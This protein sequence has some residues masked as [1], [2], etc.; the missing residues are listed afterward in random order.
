[1]KTFTTYDRIPKHSIYL[2]STYP[3]GSMD[4]FVADAIDQA[5]EPVCF[6]DPEGVKHY[7]DLIE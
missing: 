5:I 3:D 6:R 4:E 2:G 7:F 1:M